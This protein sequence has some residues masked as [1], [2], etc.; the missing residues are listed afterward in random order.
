MPIDLGD[1]FCNCSILFTVARSV[2]Y[3]SSICVLSRENIKLAFIF[4][5]KSAA[6]C[7][8]YT[9]SI[10]LLYSSEQDHLP[11][12]IT[13]FVCVDE[14]GDQ[15]QYNL[16]SYDCIAKDWP[17]QGITVSFISSLLEMSSFIVCIN[18]VQRKMPC[19]TIKTR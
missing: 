6:W 2:I 3:T 5:R 10:M 7:S 11:N 16:E 8:F 1:K 9:V 12:D 14:F 4:G 15:S 19:R 17:I 18:I 13:M